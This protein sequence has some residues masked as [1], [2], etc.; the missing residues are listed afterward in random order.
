M[1]PASRGTWVVALLALGVWAWSEWPVAGADRDDPAGNR[2]RAFFD[3]TIR[4]LH[5]IQTAQVNGKYKKLLRRFAVPDDV[6]G[7]G[8]FSDYGY[9]TGTSYAGFD[10]LPV[11]YWVYVR[12]NWYI[13]GVAKDADLPPPPPPPAA[14][15]EQPKPKAFFTQL[16]QDMVFFSVA[17]VQGKYK[18]LLRRIYVPEDQGSYG[19]FHDYGYSATSAWAGYTDLPYG[20]WVYVYPYWFIWKNDTIGGNPAI[21]RTAKRAYGPEQVT[22]EP[23]VWPIGGDSGNAWCSATEDGE[24][25]W[26]LME[27]AEPISAASVRVYATWYPGSLYK[28]SVFKPDGT[29]VEVWTGKD[30][31]P[32]EEE[33]G[34]SE[35]PVK[36]NFKITKVKIYLNSKDIGGWNEIDAVGVMD[37]QAKMHWAK[38]A[39]ASST[40]AAR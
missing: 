35:I 13:W 12:P 34:I 15:R 5:A 14:K 36:V 37:V 31:T 24:N 10:D 9:Y 8:D 19:D 1:R 28:V 25:E 32:V 16:R 22:G 33:K 6:D 3:Q 4:D 20:H 26:L 27:Y 21:P 23:D 11:G 30:P 40:W 18:D 29:E 17:R 2:K 38:T 7:Y 39:T